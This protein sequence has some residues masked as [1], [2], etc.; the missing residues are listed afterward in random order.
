MKK[1]YQISINEVQ[2]LAGSYLYVNNPDVVSEYA[3]NEKDV[4]E[5]LTKVFSM[6]DNKNILDGA[7]LSQLFFPTDI[8]KRFKVFISHSGSDAQTVRTLAK[9]LELYGLHCFVDWMVW[10]DLK[11]LQ[12]I[13]DDNLC[14]PITKPNGGKTYSYELRNHTT[15]HTHAMLSMALLDM[16]DQCD[17]CLF[18]TSENSTLQSADFG[19]VQTLSPWIY[20]EISYMNHISIRERRMFSEGGEVQPIQIAHPLDLSDFETLTGDN[21][22]DKLQMA[23]QLNG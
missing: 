16:I 13:V 21:L 5:H 23:R 22:I 14:N 3:Q 2:K 11:E 4:K 6:Y 15:A 19:D 9:V 12:L 8:T 17:I 20:E 18:I 10:G 1:K 7:S